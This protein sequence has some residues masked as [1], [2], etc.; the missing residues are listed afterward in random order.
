[1]NLPAPADARKEL[2]ISLHECRI[3]N[4]VVQVS[5]NDPELLW[6]LGQCYLPSRW[7]KLS[8]PMGMDQN[9]IPR[10]LVVETCWN[11]KSTNNDPKKSRFACPSILTRTHMYLGPCCVKVPPRA[12]RWFAASQIAAGAN[13][14]LLVVH[15][16][17]AS[18]CCRLANI[19]RYMTWPLDRDIS[20]HGLSIVQILGLIKTVP[21]QKMSVKTKSIHYLFG[22]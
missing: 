10:T 9:G 21:H 22:W 13:R 11:Q 5:N 3:H 12:R 7:S 1:M 20:R 2:V 4:Q 14:S 8:S 17:V 16:L 6:S 15:F 18:G 19:M